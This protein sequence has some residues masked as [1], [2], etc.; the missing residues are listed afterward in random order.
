M[1]GKTS[2]IARILNLVKLERKEISAV[3]FYAIMNGLIL[4]AIPV[5]IQ[6]LIG[7]AQTNTASASIVVLIVLIVSSVFIAGVLQIKQMQLTEKIQQ[8]IFVRYSFEIAKKIPALK[9]SAVDNY[10]LPELIN[11]FFDIVTLQKKLAKLLLAFPLAIIQITFGLLLLA[12]YHPVFIA[13][14]VLLILIIYSI[15]FFSGTKGLETSLQESAYKYKVA[16]WL[17]EMA[18]IIRSVKFAKSTDFHL[19]KTDEYVTRYLNARTSHFKILELQ[20]KTLIGFKTLVTFAMLVVGTY[21]LLNQQLN[22]GQFIAAE[23]VILT[24]IGSVE[25]LIGN[26]DSVYDVLTSVEKIEKI[27]DKE[28]ETSG[29]ML[30]ASNT[31]NGLSIALQQVFFRYAGA[32]T[33]TLNNISFTVAANEKVCI[34]GDEG[35][36]KSTLLRLLAGSYSDFEGAVLINDLPINNYDLQSLRQQTGVVIS[37]Q[38]IFEGTL[39]DNICMGLEDVDLQEI[40]SLCNKTGLTSFISTLKN[41]FDTPLFAAGRKLPAHAVKKILLVRALINKPQLLLLEEPW[42]GLEEQHQQQIKQL[43]LTE[44]NSTTVLVITRD[45]AF[46]STCDK[47]II[48]K[49][50]GCH[51]IK[52]NPQ[53]PGGGEDL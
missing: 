2:P 16:G 5:G 33:Q 47:T 7:F 25:K 36:G 48:L 31:T 13:F 37:Q 49:E 15:L 30:L 18:R 53:I 32:T 20:F 24:I 26:L 9:L 6:A 10:Y 46:A 3:Y 52:G 29:S 28:T 38:D 12:F 42:I 8:K 43:L 11:R 19:H 44:M 41:G 50:T 22:V 34:Q 51:I 21:L 23:I 4:L 1:T 27:T 39:M 40:I 17:E 14:G 45:E 35:T